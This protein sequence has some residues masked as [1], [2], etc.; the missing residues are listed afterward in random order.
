LQK[1]IGIGF[2][3]LIRFLKGETEDI[4]ANAETLINFIK[5]VKPLLKEVLRV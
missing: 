1:R 4:D 2:E 3:S 5:T